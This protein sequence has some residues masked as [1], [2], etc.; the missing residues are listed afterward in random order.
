[1]PK[2]S[3]E[4]ITAAIQ[5]FE[6]QKGQIDSQISELRAMLPDS[7]E[8]A[9]TPEA[10]ARKRKKFSASAR[11]RWR[12]RKKQD[13]PKSGANLNRQRQPRHP[14]RSPS[15]NS[16]LL[17]GLRSLPPTTKCGHED[18]L[19]RRRRRRCR[20][21]YRFV[22]GQPYESQPKAPESDKTLHCPSDNSRSSSCGPR[23]LAGRI[24]PRYSPT[25]IWNHHKS[26]GTDSSIICRRSFECTC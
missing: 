19:R 20:R 13:G 4:I 2:L 11:P 1:M 6:Q 16:V 8:I 12:W 9:A 14:H 18:G 17:V 15:A 10:P 21:S 22:I 3:P 5:G 26:P 23:T 24:R 7:T 25:R